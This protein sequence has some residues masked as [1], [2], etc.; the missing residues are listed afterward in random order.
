MLK[1]TTY[2]RGISIH[3]YTWSGIRCPSIIWH[4]FWQAILRH[5]DDT[6]FAVLLRMG[7][8]LVQFQH[9]FSLLRFCSLSHPTSYLT[10]GAIKAFQVSLV[11]PVTFL[12]NSVSRCSLSNANE[13]FA[14]PFNSI[15]VLHHLFT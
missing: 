1:D 3:I 11:K 9:V 13:I 7:K 5:K 8:I 15:S 4:F 14:P 10:V 12:K 2:F 6:A